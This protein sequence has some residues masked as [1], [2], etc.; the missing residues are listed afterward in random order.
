MLEGENAQLLPKKNKDLAKLFPAN[1]KE[2]LSFIKT[3]KI[4]TS[5]EDDLIRLVTY[6][7][8]L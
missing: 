7:S 6:I 4:K 2:I 8:S 5:R 3:N 1:S